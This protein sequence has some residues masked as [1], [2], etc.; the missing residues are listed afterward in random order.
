MYN[1]SRRTPY[2]ISEIIDDIHNK[3][4]RFDHP[5]QRKVGRWTEKQALRFINSML[6]RY[7]IPN[8]YILNEE[9]VKKENCFTIIDGNQRL[10]TIRKYFDT[11]IDTPWNFTHANVPADFSWLADILIKQMG[12]GIEVHYYN[13]NT[14]NEKNALLI[15][16][17]IKGRE[18]WS[19]LER[20]S[21]EIDEFSKP[22]YRQLKEIQNALASL[23]ARESISI[24]WYSLLDRLNKWSHRID[25]EIEIGT[26]YVYLNE[27]ENENEIL[28]EIFDRLN[29]G[30][31]PKPAELI[32]NLCYDDKL[33]NASSQ[34]ALRLTLDYKKKIYGYMNNINLCDENLCPEF[35]SDDRSDELFWAELFFSAYAYI[36]YERNK[37]KKTTQSIIP[38]YSWNVELIR[39][40]MRCV[41][42]EKSKIRQINEI[43]IISNTDESAVSEV[44]TTMTRSLELIKLLC[45]YINPKERRKKTLSAIILYCFYIV[46]K[47]NRVEYI[48]SDFQNQNIL[49]TALNTIK[50]K[51]YDEINKKTNKLIEMCG[52]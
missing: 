2:R 50:E 13:Q 24:I 22:S 51:G 31:T 25:E 38:Y 35:Q 27:N 16:K 36:L 1:N 17:T 49:K 46:N 42:L 9:K 32:N 52:I 34:F 15:K 33:W 5:C 11:S 21:C 6:Q 18:Q 12:N 48:I 10:D 26:T 43:N 41:S 8:V 39:K 23:L 44:E 28:S 29:Y 45:S 4:L 40:G 30:R 20:D 7:P 3:K 14:H 19:I 37:I 47:Y